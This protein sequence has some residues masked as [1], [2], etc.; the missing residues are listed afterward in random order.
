MYNSSHEVANDP[1][2]KRN[3]KPL[4]IILTIVINGIVV[5]LMSIPPVQGFD[6]FDV[7]VLPLMNAIFN[8]FTFLFLLAALIAIIKK[9][10]T[11]HR[12]FIYAAFTTTT[13]FLVTY[14]AHHML[15][16]STSYGGEG[17]LRYIYFF[18]LIT[19]IILAA[20][21]VPL[22]LM[23]VTRAWNM[24]IERHRKIARWTMPL[25]LYVSLTGVLVYILISPY[26]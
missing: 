3:Y 10:V 1:V 11:L 2:K 6:L 14:V 25:W 7:K 9:N 22:A 18:I 21:I 17:P 19:H 23:A 13:F 8:S 15:S 5:A 26:Y 4:I 12:R 20:V 24:E 16:E